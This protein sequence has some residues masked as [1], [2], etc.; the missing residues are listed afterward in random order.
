[1]K[2]KRKHDFVNERNKKLLNLLRYSEEINLSKQ[3]LMTSINNESLSQLKELLM[4]TNSALLNLRSDLMYLIV[5][6]KN[7]G[8]DHSLTLFGDKIFFLGNEVVVRISNAISLLET[9]Q[10]Q[11]DYAMSLLDGNDK[12]QWMQRAVETKKQL[13][14]LKNDTHF[15]GHDGYEKAETD[16]MVYLGKLYDS[17]V[18]LKYNLRQN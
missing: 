4:S 17:D 1:M 8:T 6:H 11:F 15:A 9:Q 16:Y 12:L 3:I 18:L 10:K 5:F 14:A 2:K 7:I 13:I